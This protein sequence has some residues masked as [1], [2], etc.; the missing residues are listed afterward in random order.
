MHLAHGGATRWEKTHEH[1]EQENA[2][3]AGKK[4]PQERSDELTMRYSMHDCM[5]VMSALAYVNAA[6]NSHEAT[7]KSPCGSEFRLFEKSND[8]VG[9]L[10]GFFNDAVCFAGNATE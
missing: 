4:K 9:E 6:L 2:P 3:F 5:V 7:M 10:A 8:V 1:H